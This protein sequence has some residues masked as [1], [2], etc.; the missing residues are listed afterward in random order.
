M[1]ASFDRRPRIARLHGR[2]RV[3]E[4]GHPDLERVAAEHP[5]HPS[6]RAVVV[7]DVE[8]ISDSC[9]YGVPVMEMV[10]ERNLLQL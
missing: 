4:P 8:Q 7:V 10:E 6:T 1:F 9:G 2:G 5:V 3:C